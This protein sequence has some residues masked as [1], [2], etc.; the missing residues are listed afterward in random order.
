MQD[1][2]FE[3][4]NRLLCVGERGR[5]LPGGFPLRVAHPLHEVLSSRTAAAGRD[6]TLDLEDLIAI[7]QGHF[8][9]WTRVGQRTRRK[10]GEPIAVS[11]E[12]ADVED[13]MDPQLGWEIEL[14]RIG[15]GDALDLERADVLEGKL[16]SSLVGARC[17]VDSRT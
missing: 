11:L 5:L 7:G 14:V 3:V 6:D 9:R 16:R 13:R 1:P 4:G 17:S 12:A 10:L 15:V 8:G 2:S